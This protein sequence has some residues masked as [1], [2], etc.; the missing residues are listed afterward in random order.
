MV[1]KAD[2]LLSTIYSFAVLAILL[3]AAAPVTA[4][5]ETA[6]HPELSE[7]EMLIACSDCHKESTPDI[8]QEW[9]NSVHGIAMVKCY[10]CHGTFESFKA[11]PTRE[12]CGTCHADRL[13]KYPGDQPCWECHVPHSFK[14]K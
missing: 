7:Q 14:S 3:C 13:I 11:T 2:I 1:K 4:N 10:Q 9:Y 12:N 5:T 8:E 6:S